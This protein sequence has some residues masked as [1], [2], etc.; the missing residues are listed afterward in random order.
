[1]DNEKIDL[2]KKSASKR[3]LK[4]GLSKMNKP[5][6]FNHFEEMAEH[7]RRKDP[8]GL[9]YEIQQEMSGLNALEYQ[10]VLRHVGY[11]IKIDKNTG[12]LVIVGK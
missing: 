2:M 7:F 1:M 6:V 11:K 12:Y 5:E 4:M 9:C 8:W 10:L 3:M